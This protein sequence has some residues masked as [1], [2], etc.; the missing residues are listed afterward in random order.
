MNKRVCGSIVITVL[1]GLAAVFTY[2]F[3]IFASAPVVDTGKV[4]VQENSAT[5][6]GVIKDDGGTEIT[7]CGFNWG[8]SSKLGKSA[9]Y[10]R[11]AEDSHDFAVAVED[12]KDGTT[13]YYQAYA[14]NTKG[15]VYGEVKSFT[16]PLRDRVA[17]EISMESPQDKSTVTRGDSIKITAKS[18]DD[19]NVAGMELFIDDNSQLKTEKGTL[20]Y[21]WDTRGLP[22]GTYTIKVTATDSIQSSEK[23]I[24]LYI[25][26]KTVAADAGTAKTG[27]KVASSTQTSTSSSSNST[28]TPSA[29]SR[30]TPATNYSK[31]PKVSKNNGIYGQFNYRDLSGGR[32]EIDPWWIAQNIVTITLP[33]LN[34]KVQVHR[35]AADNFIQ[36]FNY[37]KNGTATI[38]GRQ[39]SLLSLIKTM[40]G[41]FVTRHVNWNPSRGLSNHSWG[42]AIDINASDHFRYVNPS[43]EPNDP[44]L[45]LWEKAFKPAG[46]SWGNSYSDA[47][48][49]E[50]LP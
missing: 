3:D 41:T 24:T 26:D 15:I 1:I 5:I 34:Q 45:I 50:L 39:V 12:L 11:N 22:A 48:H 31:Y 44:N 30:S 46:F 35:E 20:T 19:T 23:E 40:N 4:Q 29:V 33:G 38:N 21:E 37:I 14:E 13:Y 9:Q 28:V 18:T 7:R 42:T 6:A 27:T 36:A 8:T 17:P 2:C 47:M 10:T 25:K 16:V 43:R 32:I 49:F